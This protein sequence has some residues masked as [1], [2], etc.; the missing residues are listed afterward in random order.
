MLEPDTESLPPIARERFIDGLHIFEPLPKLDFCCTP[1]G[2]LPADDTALS[3]TAWKS[4]SLAR[5]C[6]DTV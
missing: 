5:T 4:G 6:R 1:E 2:S 3:M